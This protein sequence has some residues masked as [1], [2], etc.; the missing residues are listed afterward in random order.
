[1]ASGPSSKPA[2][3]ARDSAIDVKVEIKQEAS[4]GK[5][6][7]R[8]RPRSRSRRGNRGSSGRSSTSGAPSG[9]KEEIAAAEAE[10]V[11]DWGQAKDESDNESMATVPEKGAE[12]HKPQSVIELAAQNFMRVKTADPM[13]GFFRS[14]GMNV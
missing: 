2:R 5:F 9:V 3:E 14:T 8:S 12:E 7:L 1:M 10:D 11:P 6:R 4:R 13:E